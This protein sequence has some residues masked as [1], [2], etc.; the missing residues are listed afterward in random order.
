M[1]ALH[2]KSTAQ[3]HAGK[4]MLNL[5][6]ALATGHLWPQATDL[7][8]GGDM[9]NEAPCLEAFLSPPTP[10]KLGEARPQNPNK[11]HRRKMP[12]ALP[13]FETRRQRCPNES[14]RGRRR[15][16]N[17]QKKWWRIMTVMVVMLMVMDIVGGGCWWWMLVKSQN[18][19]IWCF[20]PR[21][22]C[23]RAGALATVSIMR[24]HT[25][26]FTEE[27]LLTDVFTHSS[28]YTVGLYAEELFTHRRVYMQQLLRR[29]AIAHRR[30]HTEELCIGEVLQTG[31]FTDRSFYTRKLLHRVAFAQRGF[32]T[33]GLLHTGRLPASWKS[34]MWWTKKEK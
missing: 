5:H 34:G 19:T 22:V 33:E 2:D 32:S 21:E 15:E 1:P 25:E 7:Q 18:S 24:L 14:S 10:T 11:M 30:L 23:S 29:A 3:P 20:S 26:G 31:A 17:T 12:Q 13:L 9:W 27:L 6:L 8:A 4:L 16:D 28:C